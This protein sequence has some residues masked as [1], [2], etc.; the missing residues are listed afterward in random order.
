MSKKKDDK[1]F[2]PRKVDL[3][4]NK[5]TGEVKVIYN[6]KTYYGKTHKEALDKAKRANQ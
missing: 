1:K 4:S 2:D 3:S 5:R 6:G